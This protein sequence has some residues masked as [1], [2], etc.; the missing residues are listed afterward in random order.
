MKKTHMSEIS[1]KATQKRLLHRKYILKKFWGWILFLNLAHCL[2]GHVTLTS[3]STPWSLDHNQFINL[4]GHL[5]LSGASPSPPRSSGSHT[6][7][8]RQR[9]TASR[10]Q[11]SNRWNSK[12]WSAK[13][14]NSKPDPS[15]STLVTPRPRHPG[16]SPN[17][18]PL[19][20]PQLVRQPA[21]QSHTHPLTLSLRHHTHQ[22]YLTY[23]THKCKLIW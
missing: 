17:L 16:R 2:T 9:W 13:R 20:D 7:L 18:T 1:V 11:I 22:T 6:L 14:Q 19:P 10:G 5:I 4:P 23:R 15:P 3:F 21:T 8:S 12:G